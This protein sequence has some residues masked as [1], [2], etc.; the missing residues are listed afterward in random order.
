MSSLPPRVVPVS[1]RVG[2]TDHRA[3]DDGPLEVRM[4]FAQDDAGKQ[5][6]KDWID[7]LMKLDPAWGGAP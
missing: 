7:W 5:A 2:L 1:W 6:I 4:T 3:D